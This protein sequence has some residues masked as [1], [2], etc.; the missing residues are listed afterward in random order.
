M[1]LYT[2]A[3]ESPFIGQIIISSEGQ[4]LRCNQTFCAMMGYTEGQLKEMSWQE[5]IHPDDIQKTRDYFSRIHRE[6]APQKSLSKRYLRR[7]GDTLDCEIYASVIPD[8]KGCAKCFIVQILDVS[9]EKAHQIILAQEVA[10][11]TRELRA[12]NAALESFAYATSHDLREP[13]NKITAFGKRLEEKYSDKLDEKGLEYLS[14]MNSAAKR[15]A[16]LI[17]D[18]L[19]YSRAGTSSDTAVSV[20]LNEV[21]QDVLSDLQIRIEETDAV[22]D[23]QV[24]VPPVMGHPARFHQVFQNIIGNAIKFKKPDIPPRIEITGKR[25]GTDVEITVKD[26]GIGFSPDKASEIFVLF[27][28]LHSRFEYP[29]TGIGLAICRRILESYG[30]SITAYSEPGAGSNFVLRIPIGEPE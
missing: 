22:V 26:N 3:F 10:N 28:R 17:D 1:E 21:I 14:I 20:D 11:R 25:S 13:L 12:S 18:L 27:A 16:N 23:V 6:G 5:V 2:A 19:E 7:S 29:G 15:M 30:G 8:Q 9:Q 24:N 4:F